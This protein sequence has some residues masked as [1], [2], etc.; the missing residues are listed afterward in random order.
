MWNPPPE[1]FAISGALAYDG[2]GNPP[3][4]ADLVVADGRISAIRPAGEL[5]LTGIYRLSGKGLSLAP[6][7]IDAHSHSE[8]EILRAPQ[9]DS[10]ISQGVT[11]EVTGQC[12][13]SP[14]IAMR[15]NERENLKGEDVGWDDL[16]TYGVALKR[17]E[18]AVNIVTLCGHNTLRQMVMKNDDR[19]P[20]AT[21]LQRMQEILDLSLRQG[22]AGLSSGLWYIPGK[23]A[24]TNEMTELAKVLHGTGKPYV[25]HMRTEGDNLLE[26]TKEAIRIAACGSGR[27]QISHIKTG[28]PRAWDLI[29]AMLEIIGTGMRDG[30][31][32]TADRYPYL[33]SG[34]ALRMILNQPYDRVAD[35]NRVLRESA[36]ER[37][38]LTALLETPGWPLVPFERTIIC[39]S[40]LPENAH[41][42]GLNLVEIG[43]LLG[44]SPARACVKFLTEEPYVYT[45]FGRMKA[46]NL[47]RFLALAWVAC[48]S[49]AAAYPFDYSQGRAHPRAFGSFPRFFQ[50]VRRQCGAAEAIRRMTSLAATIYNIPERGVLREGFHADL[51][52]FE[53][54]KF[55]DKADF[56][57]PHTMCEGVHSVFVKGRLAFAG[58]APERRGRHGDFLR[59]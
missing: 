2:L 38:K 34:T 43:K 56:V 57:R 49:D 21:E 24:D 3:S 12:G 28:S 30:V 53:E 31:R 39:H 27:L 19:P 23:Y 52:L 17:R 20:T 48:G 25:T 40:N 1:T 11:T 6:G 42:L 46:E 14:G 55:L 44:I 13:F 9:A 32:I 47:E 5:N 10:K 45:A 7:F 36:E 26:S 35:L 58:D 54:D 8:M 15:R 29:D 16:A 4:P 18:P 41:F 51:V 37:E 33:Y 59:V 22:A 50:A